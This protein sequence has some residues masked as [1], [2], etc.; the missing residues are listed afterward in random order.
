LT[1][2]SK[3][4]DLD[5][6]LRNLQFLVEELE[7][8]D[9]L[10]ALKLNHLTEVLVLYNGTIGSEVFFEGFQDTLGVEFLRKSLDGS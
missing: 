4:V 3:S 2:N 5:V 1:G 7:D 10:V 9:S 6:L 8:L